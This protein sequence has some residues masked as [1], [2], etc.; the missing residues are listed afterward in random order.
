MTNDDPTDVGAILQALRAELLARR[1][2]SAGAAAQGNELERQLARS[3]EQLEIARV[4]SAHWPLEGATLLQRAWLLAH[5]LVRRGLRWYINPIVEQQ[6]AFNDVAARSLRLL[7]EAYDELR[8]ENA[9]LSKQP[10]ELKSENEELRTEQEDDSALL[11][12][13]FSILNSQLQALVAERGSAEPPAALPDLALLE[14]PQALAERQLVSAHWPLVGAGPLGA[15]RVL[16]K[17]L[18]RQ[19][20]R[21]L[22]NPIVEQQNAFNAALAEMIGL[23]VLADAEAR[24][25]LASLRMQK[26]KGTMQK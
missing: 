2:A 3:A 22:I 25:R 5:K 6:N 23:A 14:L 13:Q 7:I 24:A 15:A 19:Y 8:I 18:A 11:N 20:L 16:V 21:W 9:E 10:P 26:A 12:S 4:V 1:A 17:R